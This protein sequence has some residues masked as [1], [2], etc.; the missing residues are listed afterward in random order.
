[1]V[2]I[3]WDNSSKQLKRINQSTT[4]RNVSSNKDNLLGWVLPTDRKF[5]RQD[6]YNV[7]V[8][9]L[10]NSTLSAVPKAKD[11]DSQ[12][13]NGVGRY[14]EL[15]VG[16]PVVIAFLGNKNK[17]FITNLFHY[18]V[19]K[20]YKLD[21]G[22]GRH[23]P[24]PGNAQNDYFSLDSDINGIILNSNNPFQPEN[25]PANN[26][27]PGSY[28]THSKGGQKVEFNPNS[29]L[30]FGVE[31]YSYTKGLRLS[32]IDRSLLSADTQAKK[33]PHEI[34]KRLGRVYRIVNGEFIPDRIR[35]KDIVGGLEVGDIIDYLLVYMDPILERIEYVNDFV[36]G[37]E[38]FYNTQVE[39]FEG[40]IIKP[41]KELYEL[42]SQ[43]ISE[44]DILA[45]FGYESLEININYGQIID[46]I[47]SNFV[48]NSQ[49]AIVN[50]LFGVGQW[51]MKELIIQT[52]EGFFLDT[53]GLDISS[54]FSIGGIIS[55]A[56]GGGGTGD[57]AAYRPDKGSI[58]SITPPI[59]FSEGSPLFETLKF[60]KNVEESLSN[61]ARE[62][63]FLVSDINNLINEIVLAGSNSDF[64]TESI[65]ES[66]VEDLMNSNEVSITSTR[67]QSTGESLAFGIDQVSSESD[68]STSTFEFVEISY[69]KELIPIVET[70][71]TEYNYVDEGIPKTFD[72][73]N[74]YPY[75]SPEDSTPVVSVSEE[76]EVFRGG[77]VLNN[78]S[79][80]NS[81]VFTVT[82][83][84]TLPQGSS[85]E[86]VLL[87]E[88]K[89]ILQVTDMKKLSDNP[90]FDSY[91][92]ALSFPPDSNETIFYYRAKS[93]NY[94]WPSRK[95]TRP[96]RGQLVSNKFE[97]SLTS[98]EFS[99]TE[100]GYIIN[101][102]TSIEEGSSIKSINLKI[103]DGDTK[104]IEK[105]VSAGSKNHRFL[106]ETEKQDLTIKVKASS[107][108]SE[109]TIQSGIAEIEGG[110][111]KGISQ[112]GVDEENEGFNYADV[113]LISLT[114]YYDIG[115]KYYSLDI[116]LESSRPKET[117]NL[118]VEIDREEGDNVKASKQSFSSKSGGI[119]TVML[120]NDE[121]KDNEGNKLVKLGE[122]YDARI[123]INFGDG[124]ILSEWFEIKPFS[125]EP[126][127]FSPNSNTSIKQ[128]FI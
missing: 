53:F 105:S 89:N 11:G 6:K 52:M 127:T 85:I 42:W 121:F 50:L 128:P 7:F 78:P 70:Q 18:S 92:G 66:R 2:D 29:S 10:G 49:Y 100:G 84:S 4:N 9:D 21:V 62:L 115:T 112:G 117:A 120:F 76:D 71:N 51:A 36:L 80:I 47:L 106:Y 97:L 26:I 38:E 101:V 82:A 46:N 54:S 95:V 1:M 125:N 19:D 118:F 25:S 34:S 110:S 63:G 73:S 5:T 69:E 14:R 65:R 111:L 123:G 109:E 55:V 67:E 124:I 87:D 61:K 102:D 43:V 90:D 22:N 83:Q 113:E 37:I 60:G 15:E 119:R 39:W 27:L 88:N 86:L 24:S 79:Q 12:A 114:Y 30:S 64:Y 107:P 116:K 104:I 72:T 32:T 8:P 74:T 96:E 93:G 48:P 41:A 103:F 31:D 16:Q 91:T 17:P 58:I 68:Q 108:Q 28:T 126:T 59:I 75:G 33:L 56:A 99:N 23:F 98:I 13:Y 81:E 20:P 3:Q 57:P 122:V 94:L 44:G 77:I 45:L 40:N 35:E